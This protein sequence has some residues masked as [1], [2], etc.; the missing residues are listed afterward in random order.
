MFT[1]NSDVPSLTFI[2]KVAAT[3]LLPL[4]FDVF[5]L[6]AVLFITVIAIL[7]AQFHACSNLITQVFPIIIIFAKVS[8][9]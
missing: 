1:L 3:L 8:E 4:F 9:K 2:R 7:D 5:A 6:S